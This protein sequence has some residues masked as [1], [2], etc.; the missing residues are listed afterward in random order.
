MRQLR[1]CAIASRVSRA[2]RPGIVLSDRQPGGGRPAGLHA[3][4]AA[5]TVPPCP[6]P[7]ERDVAIHELPAVPREQV[8]RSTRDDEP[9]SDLLVHAGLALGWTEVGA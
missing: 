8:V 9:P 1:R 2:T 7:K 5:G 4:G 3:P 6:T